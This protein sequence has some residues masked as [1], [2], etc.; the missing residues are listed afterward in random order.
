VVRSVYPLG[1]LTDENN[2]RAAGIPRSDIHEYDIPANRV[3]NVRRSM[4][5]VI[6]LLQLTNVVSVVVQCLCLAAAVVIL[7]LLGLL[8]GP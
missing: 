7:F 8:R 2:I 1:T 3:D 5:R 6:W 4:R